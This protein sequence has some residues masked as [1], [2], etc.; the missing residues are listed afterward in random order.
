MPIIIPSKH[1]YN[2]EL[3]LLNDNIIR[4]ISVDVKEPQ[5]TNESGNVYNKKDT[6]STNI[7]G[8]V[9]TDKNAG[10]FVSSTPIY[11]AIAYV[12]VTPTYR[13]IDITIPQN[14]DNK[15][16]VDIFTGKDSND[17]PNIKAS[18]IGTV[19][20][21]I[22]NGYGA[23]VQRQDA[24]GFNRHYAYIKDITTNI[25]D[26]KNNISY[27]LPE[28]TVTEHVEYIQNQV[29]GGTIILSE[30]TAEVTLNNQD[31]LLTVTPYIQNNEYHLSLYVLCG[32]EI[33]T[34]K[35]KGGWTVANVTTPPDNLYYPISGNYERYIPSQIN[36]SFYGDVI[37]LD[38]Q[39]GTVTIGD[40]DNP[41]SFDGNELIQT[42]NTPTIENA[43]QKIIDKWD[44]GKQTAVISCPITDYYDTDGNL[45][46]N[47]TG[48]V[49]CKL[50]SKNGNELEFQELGT[51]RMQTGLTQFKVGTRT[52]TVNVTF[53]SQAIDNSNFRATLISGQSGLLAVG[54]IYQT[55]RY[56]KN[57]K[58][59]FD[60][61]DIVIPYIYTNKG[62]RP[63]SYNKDFTPKQFKVVTTRISMEQGVS[64][65]LTL[66][67]HDE[68]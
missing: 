34:L 65:E 46:I 9:Q 35:G 66:L 58:L 56:K 28:L 54:G 53:V 10:D 64:Q 45:A 42:T 38:L 2:K 50:I 19:E 22:T 12:E 68:E 21:G 25:T 23:A 40:G 16:I 37:T 27:S 11:T 4:T 44:N 36:I 17:K 43:Y 20:S 61:D 41:M 8:T 14:Y 7:L 39:D 24:Q 52:I 18:F 5:I 62:D 15:R 59:L 13:A 30:A 26:T 49:S 60:I 67:E 33:K 48:M 32:L 47:S 3:S 63:L 51:R 6:N 29:G 31:N 1:I 57:A 55:D